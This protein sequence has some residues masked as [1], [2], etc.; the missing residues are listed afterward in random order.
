LISLQATIASAKIRQQEENLYQEQALQLKKKLA[1]IEARESA[2]NSSWLALREQQHHFQHEQEIVQQNK[3]TEQ[4]EQQKESRLYDATDHEYLY[5]KQKHQHATQSHVLHIDTPIAET[6]G[7]SA[8]RGFLASVMNKY[9]G[10]ERRIDEENRQDTVRHTTTTTAAAATT[11]AT[12][13][14]NAFAETTQPAPLPQE[15]PLQPHAQQQQQQQQQD[16]D[17]QKWH[18]LNALLSGNRNDRTSQH[19]QHNR[20]PETAH[21]KHHSMSTSPARDSATKMYREIWQT[22]LNI[23]DTFQKRKETH[24][25]TR[26]RNQWQ[27]TT[28]RNTMIGV[29]YGL[30]SGRILSSHL[31]RAM[32]TVDDTSADRS[33]SNLIL[34]NATTNMEM[35]KKRAMMDFVRRKRT[36]LAARYQHQTT[37]DSNPALNHVEGKRSIY[38]YR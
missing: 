6:V 3:D 4:Q 19:K 9:A 34:H 25:A 5:E 7:L 38:G 23:D 1:G 12:T 2:L 27:G 14:T 21:T 18:R 29:E 26:T 36:Y 8:G 15:Q 30:G 13:A 32:T 20:L 37:L 33:S 28:R 16:N 17:L 11:A 31:S 24:S 22:A 10:Q 35:S